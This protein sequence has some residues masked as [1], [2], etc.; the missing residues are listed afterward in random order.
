MATLRPSG[1]PPDELRRDGA[2]ARKEEFDGKAYAPAKAGYRAQNGPDQDGSIEN[3]ARDRKAG[4]TGGYVG[5]VPALER[6]NDTR[7]PSSKIWVRRDRK[8]N[9]YLHSGNG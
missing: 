5:D 6:N 2:H 9:E 8:P 4:P 3:K 1:G 7:H